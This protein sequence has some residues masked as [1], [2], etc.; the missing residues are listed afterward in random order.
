MKKPSSLTMATDPMINTNPKFIMHKKIYNAV[1]FDGHAASINDATDTVYKFMLIKS[2]VSYGTSV[3]RQ[4]SIK[5]E[6]T[7]TSTTTY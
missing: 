3:A 7:F 6:K 2:P 5:L 1:F 4:C